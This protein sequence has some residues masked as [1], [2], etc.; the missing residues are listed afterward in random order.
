MTRPEADLAI[1][2]AYISAF[3]LLFVSAQAQV[4]I[5]P[6]N[7]YTTN[8]YE[9]IIPGRKLLDNDVYTL[10]LK[11]SPNSY[12]AYV[13]RVKDGNEENLTPFGIKEETFH[14]II[15]KKSLM[16]EFKGRVEFFV[17]T[18]NEAGVFSESSKHLSI[19]LAKPIVPTLT[20]EG[21][22]TNIFEVQYE[23]PPI[24]EAKYWRERS[25][26]IGTNVVPAYHFNNPVDGYP[27]SITNIK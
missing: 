25:I 2:C 12:L 3:M 20:V 5:N 10:D 15:P 13:Y 26:L 23:K 14:I 17:R 7:L 16:E 6:I 27:T 21:Y 22:N 11:L 18:K 4:T 1:R 8:Q 9:Q 19:N 24:Y